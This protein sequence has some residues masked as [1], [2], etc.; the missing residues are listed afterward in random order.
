MLIF[1]SPFNLNNDSVF[2]WMSIRFFVWSQSHAPLNIWTK[3]KAVEAPSRRP[4]K[5]KTSHHS[6]SEMKTG[7][8]MIWGITFKK[9]EPQLTI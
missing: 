5:L 7:L 9:T 4:E 6:A 3:T 8:C 2:Q 1:L